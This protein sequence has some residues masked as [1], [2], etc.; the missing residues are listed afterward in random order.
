[1]ASLV[2]ADASRDL[3]TLTSDVTA[4]VADMGLQFSCS[5]CVPSLNFVGLPVRK[6]LGIYR[7]SI[8]L[9]GDLD[10]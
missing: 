5:V 8:N 10:L 9:H 7:V 1:M 3:A 6:I 4:L 2:T